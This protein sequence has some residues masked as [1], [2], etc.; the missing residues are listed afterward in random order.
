VKAPSRS[1]RIAIVAVCLAICNVVQSVIAIED[2]KVIESQRNSILRGTEA[3][4]DLEH[5]DN[6][7]KR[8]CVEEQ[9][10]QEILIADLRKYIAARL[11]Q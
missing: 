4:I 10:A 11:Y 8:A 6:D 1:I 5:A 2:G 7:L 3:L 9:E